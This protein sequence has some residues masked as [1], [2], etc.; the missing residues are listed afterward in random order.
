MICPICIIYLK[1]CHIG[2]VV[3]GALFGTY[4]RLP[5]FASSLLGNQCHERSLILV[6][7]VL[8]GCWPGRPRSRRRHRRRSGEGACAGRNDPNTAAAASA[9]TA[10]TG[11]GDSHGG[12]PGAPRRWREGCPC[13][14]RLCRCR[15]CAHESR[16]RARRLWRRLV[17][18]R[19]G[20]G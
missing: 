10:H 19:R 8:F 1:C 13:R 16:R 2:G 14:C 3:G 12:G 4:N 20:V 7:R 17:R 15:R 6:H 5:G 9:S 11:P 18:R